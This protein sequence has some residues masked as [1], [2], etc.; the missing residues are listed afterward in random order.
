MVAASGTSLSK[1][2]RGAALTGREEPGR[3]LAE[4]LLAIPD[5]A[6]TIVSRYFVNVGESP[7]SSAV[8]VGDMGVAEVVEKADATGGVANASLLAYDELVIAFAA[9]NCKEVDRLVLHHNMV[10]TEDGNL[11]L[12]K[13]V[14]ALMKQRKV[15]KYSKIYEAVPLDKLQTL[16][17]DG[18]DVNFD[19][20]SIESLLM[21]FAL[22]QE[23]IA[24]GSSPLS[25]MPIDFS[26]DQE[27]EE[28]YFYLDGECGEDEDQGEIDRIEREN[29]QE[30]LSKRITTCMKLAERVT[31]LD[32]AVAVSGKYQAAVIKDKATKGV[33]IGAPR[34]V[35]DME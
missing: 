30:E 34:S 18:D 29:V 1:E 6:S 2:K 22:Q 33:H 25:Q 7:S 5:A 10:W 9:L 27:K 24:S 35:V 23:S 17:G 31:N 20:N 15:R 14:Q 26:I 13:R 11:G 16:L 8:P 21:Q 28:V 4:R 12:V 32:I 3:K 19:S